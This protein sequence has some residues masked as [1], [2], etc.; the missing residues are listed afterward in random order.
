MSN[1]NGKGV[2]K[3]LQLVTSSSFQSISRPQIKEAY[4]SVKI[5][6]AFEAA[7]Y[8]TRSHSVIT[9]DFE[10]NAKWI[11]KDRQPDGVW[12]TR[13]VQAKLF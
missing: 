9:V 8:G 12:T 13:Q 1:W 11:E 10:G 5:V 3:R 2:E 6:N 4:S 7:N